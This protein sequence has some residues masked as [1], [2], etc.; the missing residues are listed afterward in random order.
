MFSTMVPFVL[1][2]NSC[3][4]C[5]LP[6]TVA[7]YT[8]AENAIACFPTGNN[9][10]TFTTLNI[11]GTTSH[12]SNREYLVNI[13]LTSRHGA[14]STPPTT[15]YHDKVALYSAVVGEAGTGDI[16][17]INPLVTQE[18]GSGDYTAQGIELDFNNNNAHRGEA[19]AGAGLAGPSSYGLSITGAGAYRSTAA[20]LVSAPGTPIWNRGIV[21][22]NDAVAQSAFQDLMSG[23]EKSIDIRGGPIY[24]IYQ[25]NAVTKNFFAGKTSI[26]RLLVV[27]TPVTPPSYSNSNSSSNNK[28]SNSRSASRSASGSKPQTPTHAEE[29]QVETPQYRAAVLGSSLE[30][31]FVDSGNVILNGH[32]NVTVALTPQQSAV[33]RST[34]M[35]QHVYTLTPIGG[36]APGLYVAREL[37]P[38]LRY[39]RVESIVG[40]AV[41]Y[42]VEHAFCLCAS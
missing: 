14:N 42:Q 41:L 3:P 29:S 18:A 23:H 40:V 2:A 17:A 4:M 24:G 37:S 34:M 15:P 28:T 22:A 26:G 27:A 25:S 33:L 19:D 1:A 12:R 10:L 13:G 36:P 31:E 35:N 6:N 5:P 8:A 39:T 32:G 7:N 21:F 20:F 16:W 9:P 38:P 30:H 11:E